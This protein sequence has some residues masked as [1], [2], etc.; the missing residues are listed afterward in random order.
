M[1]E[2]GSVKFHLDE[3]MDPDIARALR[4][5][6]IDVTTTADAGLLGQD[7]PPHITFGLS[8]GRVIVTDDTDFLV[9]ASSGTPHAGMV[10]C[11]RSQHS[12][13]EIIEY[14]RLL[15]AVYDADDMIGRVEY[16]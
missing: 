15:H 6:G 8:N 7:D 12:L 11:R 13:G 4:R 16:L 9:L 5:D 10:F 3:H 14:L 2:G 1:P